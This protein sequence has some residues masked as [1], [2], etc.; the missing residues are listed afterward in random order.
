MA[1]F[2]LT[3][4]IPQVARPVG[5]VEM[6]VRLATVGVGGEAPGWCNHQA[7]EGIGSGVGEVSRSVS[8]QTP[9][10]IAQLPPPPSR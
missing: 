7:M 6:T 4:A 10:R 1:P 2:G 9:G 5:S 8:R 3:S